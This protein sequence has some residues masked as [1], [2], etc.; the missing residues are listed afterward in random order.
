MLPNANLSP[1]QVLS[2]N[3]RDFYAF[4]QTADGQGIYAMSDPHFYLRGQAGP[5]GTAT[6][7]ASSASGTSQTVSLALPA[8]QSPPEYA[9]IVL[10]NHADA[11]VNYSISQT[12]NDFVAGTG[13]VNPEIASGTAIAASGGSVTVLVHFPYTTDGALV[14]TFTAGAAMTNGGNVGAQL[15]WC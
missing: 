14:V 6:F 13:T 8:N 15:R 5:Q 7:A 3:E 10:I 11:T 1:N 4:Q 2:N 9:Y 12:V